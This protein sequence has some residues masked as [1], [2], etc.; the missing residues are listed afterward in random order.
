MK[1]QALKKLE[2]YKPD[3]QP[4][5]LMYDDIVIPRKGR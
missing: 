5:L 1:T 4:L 3:G 2:E